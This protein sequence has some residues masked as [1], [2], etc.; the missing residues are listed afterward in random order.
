[1]AARAPGWKIPPFLNNNRLDPA[2]RKI[3]PRR[4][5]IGKNI[6]G[7]DYFVDFST[8][9]AMARMPMG[10]PPLIQGGVEAGRTDP[11]EYSRGNMKRY[12]EFRRLKGSMGTEDEARAKMKMLRL[13]TD[14]V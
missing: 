1:M 9:D 12:L 13:L 2:M 10:Y 11:V 4:V 3:N 7:I 14:L 8:G 6:M 5:H